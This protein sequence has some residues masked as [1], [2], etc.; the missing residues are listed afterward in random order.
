MHVGYYLHGR[1]RRRAGL[2]PLWMPTR[3]DARF[4]L[5]RFVVTGDLPP[6]LRERPRSVLAHGTEGSKFV[7]HLT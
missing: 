5:G 6:A 1:A 3:R 2:R 4:P 7:V